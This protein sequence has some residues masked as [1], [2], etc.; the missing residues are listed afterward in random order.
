G[1]SAST[2]GQR[3]TARVGQ[4]NS[5]ILKRISRDC[6]ALKLWMDDTAQDIAEYACRPHDSE[7]KTTNRSQSQVE[8]DLFY[9]SIRQHIR[10]H[11]YQSNN[12][13]D[14]AWHER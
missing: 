12:K 13:H 1:L 14:H 7:V 4:N 9:I 2:P 11:E 10:G 3:P 6:L 8:R 5:S